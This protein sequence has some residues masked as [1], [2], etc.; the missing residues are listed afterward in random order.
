MASSKQTAFINSIGLK[1]LL[2]DVKDIMKNPLTDHNIFY[3]HDESNILQGYA[4]IL[5]P[6]DTIYSHGAY[7]FKFIFPVEYPF[8]PPKL[9]YMT[10]DGH[11]RFH[12]NLYR[13][14]KVCLSLLN[15]WRGEQWTSCQTIKTVLL[16]LVT[17]FDNNP[18]LHEPGIKS[19]DS[20]CNRFKEI[21]RFK[22]Y[23]CAIKDMMLKK[24]N[25]PSEFYSFYPFFKKNILLNKNTILKNLVEMKKK[26]INKKTIKTRIYRLKCYIDYDKLNDDIFQSF[27]DISVKLK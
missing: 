24:L 10:Q 12:P 16:T 2:K 22:N 27:K 9:I 3:I 6:S 5:G 25:I 18:L 8:K 14:G 20:D 23:E 11:T 13:N 17:L 19:I 26:E 21:I 1:R 7:F 15:T 4:C